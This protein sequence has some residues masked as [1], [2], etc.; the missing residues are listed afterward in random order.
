MLQKVEMKYVLMAVEMICKHEIPLDDQFLED[1]NIHLLNRESTILKKADEKLKSY[2]TTKKEKDLKEVLVHPTHHHQSDQHHDFHQN[3][4]PSQDQMRYKIQKFTL[5][6]SENQA[7]AP[8][9]SQL[10]RVR[11]KPS[12]SPPPSSPP[13]PPPPPP[14]PH[15]TFQHQS[16]RK[17]STQ[18]SRDE[19]GLVPQGWHRV[20]N[21][22]GIMSRV[23]PSATV[24]HPKHVT[25]NSGVG[26]TS[27][28]HGHQASGIRSQPLVKVPDSEHTISNSGVGGKRSLQ[29]RQASGIRS[30]PT[31]TVPHPKHP[32]SNSRVGGKRSLHGHQ[33]SGIRSQPSRS[34]ED[35]QH[36][37]QLQPNITT[38]LS[39][40]PTSQPIPHKPRLQPVK[41]LDGLAALF[42]SDLLEK[43]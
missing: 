21:Y 11:S 41:P 7:T 16:K 27:S 9:E 15:Q 36:R 40:K 14:P 23:I 17:P 22:K 18:Q 3:Q 6:Q 37:Q 13:P 29:G 12:P 38:K 20:N 32:T 25:S 33:A 24:P 19:F 30:Q 31:A 10:H 1:L 42:V 8:L 2:L 28:L 26:G 43:E 39:H 4:S 35:S 5:N 34:M